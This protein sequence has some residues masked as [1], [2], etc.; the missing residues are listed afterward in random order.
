MVGRTKKR[1]LKKGAMKDEQLG[2]EYITRPTVAIIKTLSVAVGVG[3]ND[4]S[5]GWSSTA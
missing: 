3:R 5:R 2:L 4:Q 1:M